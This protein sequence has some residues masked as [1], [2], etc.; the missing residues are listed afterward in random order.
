MRISN[1]Q[2]IDPICMF[3]IKTCLVV[4]VCVCVCFRHLSSFSV[5]KDVS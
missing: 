1:L 4:C 3:K 5:G 2:C